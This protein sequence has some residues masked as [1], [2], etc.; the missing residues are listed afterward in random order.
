MNV[1]LTDEQPIPVDVSRLRLLAEHV[2]REEGF[3]DETELTIMLVDDVNMAGYNEQ[4]M[5]RTGPTDVLAFPVESLQ[6]GVVPKWYPGDPPILLGDVIVAPDH[7]SRQAAEQGVEFSD[8]ISLMVV[9]GTLH[10]MGWDHVD[11]A[12]A[13]EMEVRERRLLSGLGMS[14]P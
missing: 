4:F 1:F 8:E 12:Q 2:I 9:H 7:V 5:S 3:P 10:L 13:E 11:D 14:R 6:P